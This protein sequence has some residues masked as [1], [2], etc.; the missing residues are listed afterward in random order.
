MENCDRKPETV[1]VTLL[2]GDQTQEYD[3]VSLDL[4]KDFKMADPNAYAP[5][6]EIVLSGGH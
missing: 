2:E 5:R 6:S 4:A 3:C 1:V